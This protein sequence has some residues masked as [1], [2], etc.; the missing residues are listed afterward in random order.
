MPQGT[1]SVLLVEDNPSDSAMLQECLKQAVPSLSRIEHV[2]SLATALACMQQQPYQLVLLDLNLPDST[3]LETLRRC[4]SQ[5]SR[6][7]VIVLTD[8]SHVELATLAVREGAQD[9]LVKESID[10]GDF[11]GR[12]LHMAI[13]RSY[14]H[15]V[16]EQ[17]RQSFRNIVD[18]NSDGILVV[19]IRGF[20]RFANPAVTKL[21]AGH[22]IHPGD[23]FGYPVAAND[24]T[25]LDIAPFGMARCV[26]EMRVART[27]WEGEEV[28]LASLRDITIRKKL[29]EELWRAKKEAEM[30]NHAKSAFLAVMSHEIRTPVSAIVGLSDLLEETS[31][32]TEQR[33]FVNWLRESSSVLL[34]L[35]ND[36]LD[37]SKVEAGE[38]RLER[39]E[40]G[41]ADLLQ[42]VSH[43]IQPRVTE[44]GLKFDCVT[45]TG[46]PALLEGDAARLRQ[47]LLNLLSNAV[48]F[49][50][51]GGSIT[52][53]VDQYQRNTETAGL[54]F[55]V[56]DTGIGIA[57]DK[58]EQVFDDFVQADSS[59]ARRYGGTGLGLGISKR[60][61]ELMGGTIGLTSSEG[62]GSSFYINV[63][64]PLAR[65]RS[66]GVPD[67][68]P[69]KLRE[70]DQAQLSGRRVLLVEANSIERLLITKLLTSSGLLVEEIPVWRDGLTLLHEARVRS[71]PFHLLIIGSERNG[72][73][74]TDML[75]DLQQTD[76]YNG[77]PV[78]ILDSEPLLK[79]EEFISVLNYLSLTKPVEKDRFMTAV[80]QVIAL[81]KSLRI[82]LVDDSPEIHMIVRAFLN[83]GLHHI[84]TAKNGYEGVEQFK[85]GRFDLV[86]MDL[87]MPGMNGVQATRAIR[88]WE[89]QQQRHRVPILAFTA[90]TQKDESAWLDA[91][92]DGFVAK[93]IRKQKFLDTISRYAL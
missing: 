40:F 32:D 6:L 49:T 27:E 30:A 47:I 33:E 20:V 92:C 85:K 29:E 53:R 8:E 73:S 24:A 79:K 87:Q 60:F 75:N 71:L 25:E 65:K 34:N 83:H 56:T 23:L 21:F 39:A 51:Y 31:L 36:I 4:R 81:G 10:W 15:Q 74:T 3:G 26:A 66:T 7:P 78:L 17:S 5:D 84:E 18:N 35:V 91:E 37:L 62:E 67:H 28:F 50:D 46:L 41:L 93:P 43:V 80:T 58:Q 86:L 61:V 68:H 55:T 22:Q 11:S 70:P 16:L 76:A 59:I 42:S 1:I 54:R 90:A 45:G 38:L 12:M 57:P 13:D 69:A 48:K 88:S 9:Y 14:F 82:L 77:Q 64:L 19:D 72:F 52:L 89:Q 44:K 2:G 63:D